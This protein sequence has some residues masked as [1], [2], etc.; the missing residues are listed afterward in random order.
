MRHL[1]PRSWPIRWRLTAL[2]VG[3]LAATL[4]ALGG[5]FLFQLDEAMITIT[6][7]HLREQARPAVLQEPRAAGPPDR[8]GPGLPPFG[9]TLFSLPRMAEGMVRRLSGPDTGVVIFD[10]NGTPIAST[11]ADEDGDTWPQAPSEQV[12]AALAGR[13]AR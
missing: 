6:A 3:I 10:I 7:D 5:L 9:P 11:D 4:L 8:R 13:E 12:R 1:D 2:S